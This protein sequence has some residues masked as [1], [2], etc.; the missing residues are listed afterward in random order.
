M[1]WAGSL[2]LG[3]V[4][5]SKQGL[6]FQCNKRAVFSGVSRRGGFPL[7]C[8]WWPPLRCAGS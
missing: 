4:V 2:K 3:K 8:C 6:Q 7:T 5:E 1:E